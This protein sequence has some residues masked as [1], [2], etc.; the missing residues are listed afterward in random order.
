[1]R[2]NKSNVTSVVIAVCAILLLS[3]FRPSVFAGTVY[4]MNAP[5]AL[6]VTPIL[7]N[8]VAVYGVDVYGV[9][10]PPTTAESTAAE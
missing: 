1:M 4:E 3:S 2:M 8:R 7:N 6:P 5:G 9:V 10:L